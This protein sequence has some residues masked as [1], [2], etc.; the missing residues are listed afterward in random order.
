MKPFKLLATDRVVETERFYLRRFIL[1]DAPFLY[2]LNKNENV[3]RYTGDLPFKNIKATE[4]FIEN[5]SH[6]DDYNM[7]RWA[8]C[9]KKQ[10]EFMGWCGLKYHPEED[11]V[12][13]GYRI[14]EKHWNKNIA[15]EVSKTVLL[16]GFSSLYIQDI[17]TYIDIRNTASCKVAEK[18][19]LKF[20]KE[21]IHEGNTTHV[22]HIKNTAV[23]AKEISAKETYAIRQQVLRPTKKS[24]D[25][26]F[27][28][29]NNSNTFHLGLFYYGSLAGV[30]SYMQNKNERLKQIIN[31]NF[32]EWRWMLDFKGR[33]L[34]MFC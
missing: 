16:Y 28:G 9:D 29:D 33:N 4:K 26:Y 5:Y 15:T 24:D 23:V 14:I 13:L 19:G 27:E 22:Y 34:E 10:G 17:Y 12:D 21:I 1:D 7:G 30:V 18:V 6:Y 3:M 8:I 32:E 11:F 31:I 20:E 2:F 25:C